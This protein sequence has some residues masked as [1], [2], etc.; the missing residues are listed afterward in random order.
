MSANKDVVPEDLYSLDDEEFTFFTSQTGIHD[1]DE[2]KE[3]VLKVQAEAYAVHPYP[4]ILRFVFIKLEISRLPAYEQFLKLGRERPG[5]IYLDVGC[6]FGNDVRKAVVDGFPVQNAVASDIVPEFWDLGHKL[7]K[8]SPETFPVPF[9]PGDAFDPE[10]LTPV[11][12]FYSPPDTPVPTLS[13]LK[14]LSPLVGHVSAIHGSLFFHLFDEPGQLQLARSLAGLLSPE[15]GSMIFGVHGGMPQKGQKKETVLPHERGSMFCH[16][17]ESW[18]ELWDG[19]VFKKGSIKVETKLVELT[20]DEM[21]PS[22]GER[23]WMLYWSV[24]RL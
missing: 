8:S 10:F 23:F 17:P 24:T 7:F 11:A 14:N 15:P 1:K 13:S 6:C 18:T 22:E 16:S 20:R 5:A 4:C 12:P 2:L 9:L 3:H 19:Q 21:L